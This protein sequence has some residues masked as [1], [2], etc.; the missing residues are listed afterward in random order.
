MPQEQGGAPPKGKVDILEAVDAAARQRD[1]DPVDFAQ[2]LGKDMRRGLF[3]LELSPESIEAFKQRRVDDPE[4]KEGTSGLQ[5]LQTISQSIIQAAQDDRFVNGYR[6]KTQY[7]SNPNV[8]PPPVISS[9]RNPYQNFGANGSVG[10]AG[11]NKQELAVHLGDYVDS[12]GALRK[13]LANDLKNKNLEVL[14]MPETDEDGRMMHRPILRE[15]KENESSFGREMLAADG[16]L[17][18]AAKPFSRTWLGALTAG[19]YNTVGQLGSLAAVGIREGASY[20]AL[21]YYRLGAPSNPV[22]GLLAQAIKPLENDSQDRLRTMYESWERLG[23]GPES[24]QG[25]ED[26]VNRGFMMPLPKELQPARLDP[27]QRMHERLDLLESN[28]PELA[29]LA[30]MGDDSAKL[31]LDMLDLRDGLKG[32][33]SFQRFMETAAMI[34]ARTSIPTSYRRDEQGL[35]GGA[36]A[37][38]SLL[39]EALG[40]IGPQAA[41]ARGIGAALMKTGMKSMVSRSVAQAMG[42]VLTRTGGRFVAGTSMMV[43]TVQMLPSV[44]KGAREAGYGHEDATNIMWLSA[45][46]I[47]ITEAALTTPY[48]M[49]GMVQKGARQGLVDGVA[50]SLLRSPATKG[51]TKEHLAIRAWNGL[52]NGLKNSGSENAFVG[53]AKNVVEGFWREGIQEMTE[54]GGYAIVEEAYDRYSGKNLYQKSRGDQY[55]L[56]NRLG[57]SFV[58]G[59]VMGAFTSGLIGGRRPVKPYDKGIAAMVANGMG[60]DLRKA[61]KQMRADGR[62]TEQEEAVLNQDIALADDVINKMNVSD[63]EVV[64]KI[65][66]ERDMATEFAEVSMRIKEIEATL[67]GEEIPEGD[68][69]NLTKE[70]GEANA[71]AQSILSGDEIVKRYKDRQS[72]IRGFEQKK[73]GLRA[74][75]AD[76][77]AAEFRQ[78]SKS[79]KERHEQARI[80]R[81][82]NIEALDAALAKLTSSKPGS[83]ADAAEELAKVLLPMRDAGAIT[84][85]D[86]ARIA[87]AL[88]V[89][90][91]SMIDE[92]WKTPVPESMKE[93]GAEWGELMDDMTLAGFSSREEA[94][95]EW[96]TEFGIV[97][98]PMRRRSCTWSVKP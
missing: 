65:L 48:L 29:K 63:P 82:E 14:V 3:D 70:L 11:G 94:M 79:R 75:D 71:R 87:Q 34:Q 90:D 26:A 9:S 2:R 88:K 36:E 31:A 1:F 55:S 60:Q 86:K 46:M 15:L 91:V 89:V 38:S 18:Q 45:P 17:Y 16:M 22:A 54:E 68:K 19:L 25:F 69:A 85:E 12:Q 23:V 5:D 73:G 43:P 33:G 61:I 53:G 74:T 66:K 41:A 40:Y 57:S 20:D 92:I 10:W 42:P 7:G 52:L 51:A 27:E 64:N 24:A 49:R 96:G 8:A 67:Q 13:L 6:P 95:D 72:L 37:I 81:S 4:Y 44:Y 58:A 47:A 35:L 93:R 28:R 78:Y 97:R 83:Y 30:Q 77:I 21:K 50:K 76:A 80:V 32:K 62:I 56:W 59:A 39:G 98:I 84:E